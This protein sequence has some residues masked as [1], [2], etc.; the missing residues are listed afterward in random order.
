MSTPAQAWCPTSPAAP[1]PQDRRQLHGCV[2]GTLAHAPWSP[3]LLTG[4]L[5]QWLLQHFG[6]PANVV[7]PQL[8]SAV[9]QDANTTGIL[10]EAI[11]RWTGTLV[12]K[13][14]ALIIKRNAYRNVRI[15][16]HD[17]VGD[18]LRGHENFSTCWVGSHTIFAIHGS[19]AACEGL[20]TETQQEL[21]QFGPLAAR[22]DLMRFQVTEVGPVST[23]EEAKQNFVAAITVGW[24]YQETWRL[25]PNARPLQH[26]ALSVNAHDC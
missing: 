25:D 11:H 18:D 6:N 22:L 9:W 12:E 17:R 15:V 10:V 1:S 2:A 26:L 20:T 19:G 23:L 16:L 5:R 3:M 14:P 8:R 24:A 4:F 21:T 13:R 7:D